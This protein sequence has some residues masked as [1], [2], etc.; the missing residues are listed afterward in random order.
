[1]GGQQEESGAQARPAL[2][3]Y[4]GAHKLAFMGPIVY[5]IRCANFAHKRVGTGLKSAC[6]APTNKKA[7]AAAARLARLSA[8]RH[9]L[10][11]RAL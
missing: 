10:T 7:N 3:S 1:M 8:G 11:G 4:R 2:G 6:T 5:C 9:P